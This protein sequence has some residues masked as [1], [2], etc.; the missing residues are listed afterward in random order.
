VKIGDLKRILQQAMYK[1]D[2][3]EDDIEIKLE[4]DTRFVKGAQ[5][6][7]DVSGSKG[8]YLDL[9]NISKNIKNGDDDERCPKCREYCHLCDCDDD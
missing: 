2:M 5:Y 6:V 1:I 7:L 8:G 9:Q 3:F 4:L